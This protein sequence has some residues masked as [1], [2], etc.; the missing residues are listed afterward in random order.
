MLLRTCWSSRREANRARVTA[1]GIRSRRSTCL[2]A[3]LLRRRARSGVRRKPVRTSTGAQ[4]M[5]KT[6]PT[7]VGTM[8]ATPA[9]RAAQVPRRDLGNDVNRTRLRPPITGFFGK[10]HLCTGGE[11]LELSADDA[12]PMKI[13]QTSVLGFDAT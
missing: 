12:V 7:D 6:L 5:E 1:T 13:D 10:P 4:K 9:G 3:P 8:S 11:V 2:A